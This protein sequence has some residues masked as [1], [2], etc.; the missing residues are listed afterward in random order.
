M[1]TSASA[2]ARDE[3]LSRISGAL[4]RDAVPD[5]PASPPPD[6][7]GA[8]DELAARAALVRELMERSADSLFDTLTISAR[9]AGW[10]VARVPDA[11]AAGDYALEVARDIEARSGVFSLDRAVQAALRADRFAAAGIELTPVALD[12]AADPSDYQSE[13]DRLRAIMASAD[14]GRDR[15][16]LRHRR[17][18]HLR[19]HPQNRRQPLGV[20]VAPRS[21]SPSQARPNP[22]ESG[23]ALHPAPRRLHR[24]RARQLHESDNRPKPHRRHRVSDSHRRPRPRRS[25]HGLDRVGASSEDESRFR[26]SR[27]R[28]LRGYIPLYKEARREGGDEPRSSAD[29]PADDSPFHKFLAP[30]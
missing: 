17:N 24:Q 25:P 6:S 27:A 28:P 12:R 16:G 5:R 8:P 2:S 10:N 20:A 23:R 15:R 7:V 3:F 30:S 14:F 1:N 18:R 11:R 22:A 13:R 9:T 26:R 19:N 29:S 4:G 21:H